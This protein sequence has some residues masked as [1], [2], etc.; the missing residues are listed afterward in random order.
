MKTI[1][2]RG[3]LCPTPLIMTKRAITSAAIGDSFQILSDNDTAKCNLLDYL[4]ELGYKAESSTD[5]SQYI[6]TFTVDSPIAS[7]SNSAAS[8]PNNAA[9][10][11]EQIDPKLFCKI[12]DYDTKNYT[13]VIKSEFMG[14]GDPT[15]GALLMRSCINSLSELDSLPS[16]IVIYNGGV[17]LAIEGTDTAESLQKL[18]K[19]GVEIIVCGTCV[20]FYGIKDRLAVG[21]ISNMYKINS[22][23]S[24]TGHIVYP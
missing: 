16:A 15:L 24:Q 14:D 21:T 9:S 17:R 1:D 12:P 13:V 10:T 3:H 22:I 8:R 6:I 11:A 23:L 5:G 4:A 20:D 18:S 19:Q 7:N 2:T